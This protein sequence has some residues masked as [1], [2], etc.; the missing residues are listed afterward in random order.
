MKKKRTAEELVNTYPGAS[1]RRQQILLALCQGFFGP[2][3]AVFN[4]RDA[5]GAGKRLVLVANTIIEE[6]EQ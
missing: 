1:D 3:N 2:A 4:N 5:K 6:T